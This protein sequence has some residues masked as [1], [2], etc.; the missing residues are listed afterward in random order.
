MARSLLIAL[1]AL[2][3]AAPGFAADPATDSAVTAA[4]RQKEIVCRKEKETGSLVKVKKTCHSREQWAY[5]D[6]TNQ[7][8]T[9][10][11]AD[12]MRTKQRGD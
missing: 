3:L 10:S 11:M 2:S 7:Q 8:F 4:D 1:S 6:D 5:I 12:D 9:R